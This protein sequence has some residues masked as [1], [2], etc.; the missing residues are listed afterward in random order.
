MLIG[1]FTGKMLEVSKQVVVLACLCC[2]A[3]F[4]KNGF[5]DFLSAWKKYARS[6]FSF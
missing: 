2:A 4:G 5:K 3:D 6:A 1:L